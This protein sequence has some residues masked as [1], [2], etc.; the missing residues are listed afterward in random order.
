MT[1]FLGMGA[2]PM[3]SSVF[4][5]GTPAAATASAGSSLVTTDGF[6]SGSRKI[7]TLQTDRGQ[8]AIGTDGRHVGMNDAEQLVLLAL[9]T[10]QGSSAAGIT[11]GQNFSSI[12]KIGPNFQSDVTARVNEA[13][14]NI[15]KLGLVR[16]DSVEFV[17]SI[18]S[19]A[20]III[21]ITNLT[22]GKP[23]SISLNGLP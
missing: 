20:G 3:G 12:R 14:A 18:G 4:G 1:T 15:I 2:A 17:G 11:V 7:S 22:T 19:R 6:Q 13:L 9:G 16:L 5:F 23:L 8:Y 21:N 10:M